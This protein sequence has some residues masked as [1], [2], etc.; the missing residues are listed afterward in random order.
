MNITVLYFAA[1][2]E[3]VGTDEESLELPT[4]V[5]TIADLAVH[6]AHVHEVLSGRLAALFP[7]SDGGRRR[8]R[9]APR[10][11]LRPR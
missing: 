8:R 10:R 2:R 6:L 3:L 1:V 4:R 9:G 11:E 7:E 5:V